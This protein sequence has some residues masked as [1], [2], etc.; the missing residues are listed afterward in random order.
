M[1]ADWNSPS[2]T[3]D[4]IWW[5]EGKKKKKII[6]E[7]DKLQCIILCVYEIL[8]LRDIDCKLFNLGAHGFVESNIRVGI[9]RWDF[10]MLIEYPG[11]VT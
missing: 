8:F 7:N 1:K 2:K 10:I 4:C 5:W 3:I 6:D 11:D 9:F